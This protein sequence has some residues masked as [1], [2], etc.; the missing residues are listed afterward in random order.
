MIGRRPFLIG[1]AGLAAIPAIARQALPT[2]ATLASKPAAGLPAP[3][4]WADATEAEGV[5][6]RMHGWDAVEDSST[7]AHGQAWVHVDSS[8]RAAWR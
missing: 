1:S 2:A 8:W 5:V 3:A 6:L 4:A 7:S